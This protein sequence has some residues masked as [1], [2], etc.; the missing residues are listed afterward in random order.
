MSVL[1]CSTKERRSPGYGCFYNYRH[2]GGSKCQCMSARVIDE[3]VTKLFL[4]AVSPAK[5]DI[6]LQA[7]KDLN[8]NLQEA[9]CSWDPQLQQADYEVE[10]ARRRYE[11]ADPG[12][13]LVAGELEAHWEEALRQREPLR[14]QHAEFQQ[15][16]YQTIRDRDCRLIEELANDLPL[17]WNAETTSMQGRKT[18][19]RGAMAH[20]SSEFDKN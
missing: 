14:G 20:R 12:N 13:R 10:L 11:S 16:H 3:A 2:K 15:C 7:L 5:I 19:L 18:L 8:D 9:C 4:S 6:A 1:H 17:V